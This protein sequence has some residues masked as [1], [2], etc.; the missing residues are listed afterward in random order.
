MRKII[1]I[2]GTPCTGKTTLSKK[3]AKKLGMPIL[4]VNDIIKSKRLFS[5]YSEDGTMVVSAAKLQKAVLQFLKDNGG[6]LVLEGHLLCEIRISG[7]RV[8]VLREHLKTLR[9]R[10]EARGYA[11]PKIR[12][13]L[14]A[15]AIDYCGETAR[16]NYGVVNE[17][18]CSGAFPK[19]LAV[20]AG[21]KRFEKERIDL[22]GELSSIIKDDIKLAV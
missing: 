17:I 7:A 14:V 8:I 22:L 21:S 10:L 6:D 15:E 18:S 12:D 19:A 5:S 4:N 20:A 2:T 9:K 3:L 1:I 11:T 13:N 16:I